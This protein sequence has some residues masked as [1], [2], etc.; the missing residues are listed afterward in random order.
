MS[1]H[2]LIVALRSQS[3]Y[4]WRFIYDHDTTTTV[5]C[6]NAFV[7]FIEEHLSAENHTAGPSPDHEM[8]EL[9][10]HRD[11]H[12]IESRQFD[13]NLDRVTFDAIRY[14]EGNLKIGKDCEEQQGSSTRS[15]EIQNIA[16]MIRLRMN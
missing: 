7:H 4:R 11:S 15:I 1:L 13:S 12:A 16:T 14:N 9:R 2:L 8:D 3:E 5:F 6:D 10:I